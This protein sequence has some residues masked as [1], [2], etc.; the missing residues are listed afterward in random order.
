M[1]MGKKATVMAKDISYYYVLSVMDVFSRFLW[2]RAPSDKCSKA[3][4]LAKMFTYSFQR[5]EEVKVGKKGVTS[6]ML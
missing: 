3:I 1:D 5:K 6:Q 4:A 2:L